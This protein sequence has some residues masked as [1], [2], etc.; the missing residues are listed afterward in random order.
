MV[1]SAHLHCE[2]LLGN[3]QP[4]P[5]LGVKQSCLGVAVATEGAVNVAG[6]R[7]ASLTDR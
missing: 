4:Q 7:A 5:P 1:V 3:Q 2:A 6:I